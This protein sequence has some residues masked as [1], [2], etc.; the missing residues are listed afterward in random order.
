VTLATQGLTL[1]LMFFSGAILGILLD[2]YRLLVRRFHWR[3]WPISLIDLFFWVSAACF[4]FALLLW[5]NWGE[6]R[7]Y[8]MLAI[9]AGLFCYFRLWST[10]VSKVLAFFIQGIERMLQ[11]LIRIISSLVYRPIS[12]LIRYIWRGIRALSIMIWK[13]ITTPIVW[14]LRS[15]LTPYVQKIKHWWADRKKGDDEADE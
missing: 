10:A 15:L 8:I 12:A 11:I 9:I 2:L 13:L 7:F 1:S 5:S 6:M 14:L 4:V 3:G